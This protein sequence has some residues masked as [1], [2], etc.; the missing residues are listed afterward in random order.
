L[1]HE[2]GQKQKTREGSRYERWVNGTLVGAGWHN[3][4]LVQAGE[5]TNNRTNGVANEGSACRS[6]VPTEEHL[7]PEKCF[8][9][10]Y[11]I[12]QNLL[13][14]EA[15]DPQ[16][17]LIEV[18]GWVEDDLVEAFVEPR[19]RLAPLPYD[20]TKLDDGAAVRG[21]KAD[22]ARLSVNDQKSI[23]NHGNSISFPHCT[24]K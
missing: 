16:G 9:W 17:V 18:T 15:I 7:E 11:T 19:L 5:G 24:Q 10:S 2:A 8:D 4:Q 12:L 6:E 21:V 14:G 23:G 3:F 22:P 1:R 20:C 13:S